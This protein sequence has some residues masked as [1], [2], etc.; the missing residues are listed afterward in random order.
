MPVWPLL[1]GLG[2]V[3]VGCALAACF[4]DRANGFDV[5]DD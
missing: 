2:L 4:Y 5:E 3:F 1:V